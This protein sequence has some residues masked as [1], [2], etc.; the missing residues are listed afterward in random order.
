MH[1]YYQKKRFYLKIKIYAENERT[2]K[3][4]EKI[5]KPQGNKIKLRKYLIGLQVHL[6]MAK[7]TTANYTKAYCF[8]G[9]NIKYKTLR[10]FNIYKEEKRYKWERKLNT[11]CLYETDCMRKTLRALLKY[12]INRYY[13]YQKRKTVQIQ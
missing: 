3:E 4:I 5:A 7:K 8:W 12:I 13:D 10:G 1:Q 6:E 11:K 9:A 2:L